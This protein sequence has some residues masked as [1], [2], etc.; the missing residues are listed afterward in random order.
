MKRIKV[1]VNDESEFWIRRDVKAL[2]EVVGQRDQMIAAMFGTMKDAMPGVYH[3]SR[4]V[5]TSNIWK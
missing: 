2:A 1:A 5:P 3:R 4:T